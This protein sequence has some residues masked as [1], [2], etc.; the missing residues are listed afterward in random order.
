[1]TN[2]LTAFLGICFVLAVLGAIPF[3]IWMFINSRRKNW[4]LVGIQ[5]AVAV[6]VAAF[7]W[8]G[9]AFLS[10]R[11]YAEFLVQVYDT[12]TSLGRAEFSYE[13]SRELS[14]KG[15]S[16]SVYKLPPEIRARFEKAD[17]RLLKEF[18]KLPPVREGWTTQNWRQ[19]PPDSQ[20]QPH[21]EFALDSTN[22]ERAPELKLQEEAIRKALASSRTYY[23]S[24]YLD[25]E[26][27]PKNID[28]FIVDLEGDQLYVI[29]RNT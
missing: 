25:Q 23:S 18:P 12:K 16:L 10:A 19:G 1:M 14:G 7:L 27:R 20:F 29:N 26:N 9:T 17:D 2:L 11:V 8:G 6:G 4:K 5:A 24:F 13:P 28:L 22:G 15:Y 3:G 21:I